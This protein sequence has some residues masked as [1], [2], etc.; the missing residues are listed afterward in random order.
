MQSAASNSALSLM[1]TD[2]EPE[3]DSDDD[4]YYSSDSE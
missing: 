4:S 3:N 1:D 2:N